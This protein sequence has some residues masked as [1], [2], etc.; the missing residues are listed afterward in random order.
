VGWRLRHLVV[1]Y[2]A[3][4]HRIACFEPET[5]AYPDTMIPLGAR[6]TSSASPYDPDGI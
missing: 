2:G 6:T 1:R 4:F 5:L 3:A